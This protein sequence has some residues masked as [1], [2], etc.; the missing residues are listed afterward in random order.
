MSDAQRIFLKIF[1]GFCLLNS[2]FWAG[3]G[4]V[5]ELAE[6]GVSEFFF[7]G[8]MYLGFGFGSIAVLI[9]LLGPKAPGSSN[10]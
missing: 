7:H 1:G 9:G 5:S 2:I 3:K 10:F 6:F 4:Y 8:V